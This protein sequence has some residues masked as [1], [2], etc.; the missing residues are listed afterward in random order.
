MPN[1]RQS[2]DKEWSSTCTTTTGKWPSREL[3]KLVLK[4]N[5]KNKL[6]LSKLKRK[7]KE[8]KTWS[9]SRLTKSR[10]NRKILLYRTTILL[11]PDKWKRSISWGRRWESLISPITK[12]CSTWTIRWLKSLIK[13]CY[14]TKWP[15]L[16]FHTSKTRATKMLNRENKTVSLNKA[17]GTLS[18]NPTKETQMRMCKNWRRKTSTSTNYIAITH[19]QITIWKIMLCFRK[20]N[21]TN[22]MSKSIWKSL[23]NKINLNSKKSKSNRNE[24]LIMIISDAHTFTK[25]ATSKEQH[26]YKKKK[27][28]IKTK[29]WLKKTSN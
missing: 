6:I 22:T 15:L 1:N 13:S 19:H 27:V 20:L 18:I 5:R 25:W 4:N 8:R 28:L 21:K 29:W 26:G 9:G 17:T 7:W 14:R 23:R 2:K 11:W 16:T 12:T 10:K 3:S 24:R